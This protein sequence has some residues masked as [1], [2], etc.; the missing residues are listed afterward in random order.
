[1]FIFQTGMFNKTGGDTTTKKDTARAKPVAAKAAACT[2][3]FAQTPVQGL[4][5]TS[6]ETAD[7]HYKA[8]RYQN[9]QALYTQAYA[10]AGSDKAS[11]SKASWG[12]AQC[13]DKQGKYGNI[14]PFIRITDFKAAGITKEEYLKFKGEVT[15][16]VASEVK[17]VG[18]KSAASED[19]AP[20]SHAYV[21]LDE[22]V[23]KG[24]KATESDKKYVAAA[25]EDIYGMAEHFG[26]DKVDEKLPDKTQAKKLTDVG[27]AV[28]SGLT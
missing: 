1:M 25:M 15:A 20:I 19:D 5:K 7:E 21:L 28:M 22:I 17:Q 3:F 26:F 23:R 11:M 27:T 14:M 4:T 2:P 10:D 13:L 16:K 9:A 8:G 6:L 24:T 18:D 12:I